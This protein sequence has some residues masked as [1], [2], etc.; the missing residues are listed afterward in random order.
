MLHHPQTVMW[1]AVLR[2]RI[3]ASLRV[4]VP[5]IGLRILLKPTFKGSSSRPCRLWGRGVGAAS[6]VLVEAKARRDADPCN[7][8][9]ALGNEGLR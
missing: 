7:S 6:A 9:D 3:E 2:M 4:L 5:E 1:F 8:G